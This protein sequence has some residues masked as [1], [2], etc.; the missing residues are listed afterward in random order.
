MTPTYPT[1]C[2][3]HH[4]GGPWWV[5]TPN[6]SK[7][8]WRLGKALVRHVSAEAYEIIPKGRTIATE[9]DKADIEITKFD[10]STPPPQL[11]ALPLAGMPVY[12]RERLAVQRAKVR[13]VLILATPGCVIEEA[14][15]KGLAKSIH[16]P[17]YLVAPFYGADQDGTRAGLAPEFV[18]RIK[19]FQY[20]QF[21]WDS[22]PIEGPKGSVLRFDQI[23][24]VEPDLAAW[25]P[26]TFKLSEDAALILEEQLRW[27]ITQT[28]PAED[29]LFAYFRQQLQE[30]PV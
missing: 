9:H 25:K 2:L 17:T 16:C 6:A 14:I 27:H 28:H 26:T 18:S 12:P 4:I 29:S 8:R 11:T 10:A 23:Q 15:R 30:R 3:Q 19:Q 1:D 5:E 22:L 24:P 20:S 13:P 21:F 7:E